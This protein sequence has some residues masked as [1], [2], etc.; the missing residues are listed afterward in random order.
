MPR[1]GTLTFQ[2]KL[3]SVL[4]KVRRIEQ[5]TPRIAEM[6]GLSEQADRRPPVARRTCARPTWRRRWWSSS[7]RLQ[8]VMGRE[9]ALRQGESPEVA[10]AILEHYLPR[11]AGDSCRMRCPASSLAWPTAG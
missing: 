7:P 8:G 1:L 3:G 5:L 10:Q 11:Y 6:L 9:Y 2:E 4:D